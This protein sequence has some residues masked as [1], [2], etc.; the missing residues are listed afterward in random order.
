MEYLT[1]L[2]LVRKQIMAKQKKIV[3]GNEVTCRYSVPAYYSNSGPN[4]GKIIEFKPGMI[5]TVVSI[6]PK[7]TIPK[8]PH[9]PRCFDK[10]PDFLVVDFFDEKNEKQRVALNFCNAKIVKDDYVIIV[11]FT[12]SLSDDAGV[13]EADG[14][15]V[16]ADSLR[17]QLVKELQAACDHPAVAI[18]TLFEVVSGPTFQ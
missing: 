18:A 9:D 16:S 13:V 15:E 7:V 3:P 6:A 17:R 2:S 5:G 1:V 4:K 8:N 11:K 12:R 14:K 10:K